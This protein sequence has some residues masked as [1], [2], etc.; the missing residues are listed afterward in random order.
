LLTEA[1]FYDALRRMAAG[2]HAG[3]MKSLQQVVDLDHKG[4]IEYDLAVHLLRVG[5][6]PGKALAAAR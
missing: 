2:D 1:Y 4:Y 3:Q 6:M 5:S